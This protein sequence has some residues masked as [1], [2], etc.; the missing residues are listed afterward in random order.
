[1]T[2][3][4]GILGSPGSG[5]TVLAARLYAELLERGVYGTR[6]VTEYAHEYLGQGNK[7][8][9][10]HA[11]Q[12]VTDKQ[13]HREITAEESNFNPIICDSCL[14][15]AGIY[16]NYRLDT[17]GFSNAERDMFEPHYTEQ[18]YLK[19]KDE[20]IERLDKICDY[21]YTIYVPLFD[22]TDKSNTFRLHD[23]NQ[24]YELDLRMKE[25]LKQFDN[26]RRAPKKLSDR[27][28]FIK[29]IA[30]EIEEKLLE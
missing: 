6:L 28:Y 19:Q 1:M 7:L 11:Q 12:E 16:L 15:I 23:G 17:Q 5:K 26:V 10:M 9:T 25:K 3:K 20:Y 27:E 8:D 24:S 4:I 2:I 18:D 21:D 30:S 22:K 13:L 14:W 29:L